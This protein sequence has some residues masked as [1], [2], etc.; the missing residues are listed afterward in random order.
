[1]TSKETSR[2]RIPGAV[3]PRVVNLFHRFS[4][5]G[6]RFGTIQG[7]LTVGAAGGGGFWG[8]PVPSRGVGLVE[9]VPL[10]GA[11]EFR[12]GTGVVAL[13]FSELAWSRQPDEPRPSAM[14]VEVRRTFRSGIFIGWEGLRLS[15]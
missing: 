8:V 10:A 12:S 11:V 7:L 15:P 5:L 4:C 6:E 14:A 3:K 2:G 13:D 9:G 1:M